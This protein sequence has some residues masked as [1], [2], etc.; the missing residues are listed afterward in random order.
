MSKLVKVGIADMRV[1]KSPDV[2]ISYGLGSCIG[3]SLYDARSKIGGLAHILLPKIENTKNKENPRKF[4]DSSIKLMIKEMVARGAERARLVA[5]IAGGAHMFSLS[6]HIASYVGDRN[7]EAVK[8]TLRDEGIPLIA[9][10]TGG[11]MGRTMRLETETGNV[12]IKT[13]IKGDLERSVSYLVT[14]PKPSNSLRIFSDVLSNDVKGLC[15]TRMPMEHFS[16]RLDLSKVRLYWLSRHSKSENSIHPKDLPKMLLMVK[17]FSKENENGIIFLE[18]IDYLIFQNGYKS[19][20]KFI[21]ALND[22]V[23]FSN[24]RMIVSLSE[25]IVEKQELA[26]LEREMKVIVNDAVVYRI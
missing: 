18:G 24:S 16:S 25:G 23:M 20:I 17:Q 19:I 26:M 6:N 2:L 14:E 4:A 12:I 8:T 7:I 9:E 22:Q 13:L 5:K 10:D 3:I 11:N 1:A 15:F 21:Q